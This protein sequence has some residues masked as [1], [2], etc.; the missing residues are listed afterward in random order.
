MKRKRPSLRDIA[1]NLD[2]S[3]TTVSFVLNG[4]AQEMR[5]SEGVTQRILD[6]AEEIN[7]TPNQLAQSLR[8]GKTNIIVF[9]VEDISNPFFAQLARIIEIIAYKKGYKVIFC[10][11]ENSD[12]RTKEL[13]NIFRDRKVDG[14][15]IIPS[16]GAKTQIKTLL[17]ENIP[18][19]LFDRYIPDLETNYVIID[20]ENATYKAT[21]HLIENG[22]RQIGLIT[23]MAKQT[24]MMD[25]LKGYNRA[26][27]E[28]NLKSKV[29]E[30]PLLQDLSPARKIMKKFFKE[31]ASLDSIFFTTN[32]LTQQGLLVIRENFPK[33]LKTW[34]I[35][36]FDDNTFFRIHTPSISAVAQPL[37]DIG[38]NLMNII[39]QLMKE[40]DKEKPLQQVILEAE[41]KERDSSKP[42]TTK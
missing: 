12:S 27:E 41:L 26:M 4:K 35:M 11:N 2:V 9:M 22:Y 16:V 19:V 1:S 25:R 6:Y 34:G 37:Q 15:I 13:L 32:Y 18:V 20:N 36:T 8:T 23:I 39:L 31:N 10:S 7:Y 3:V 29:L 24:Q 14:Y 38:K 28:A 40:T 42:K 5:I 21:C 33:Y 17:E 30:L